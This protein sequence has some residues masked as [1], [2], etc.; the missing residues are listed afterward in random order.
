MFILSSHYS[1]YTATGLSPSTDTGALYAGSDR[2][3]DFRSARRRGCSDPGASAL[4]SRHLREDADDPDRGSG[5]PQ[6][7]LEGGAA[8]LREAN[9]SAEPWWNCPRRDLVIKAMRRP[10]GLTVAASRCAATLRLMNL[11]QS[12]SVTSQAYAQP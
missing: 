9:V 4:G 10:R 7:Y 5:P 6:R 1:D 8:Y 12:R 2:L 3:P 11:E